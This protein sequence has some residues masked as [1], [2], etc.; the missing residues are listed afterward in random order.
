VTVVWPRA[1]P[2]Q[3]DWVTHQGHTV[4]QGQSPGRHMAQPVLG[5]TMWVS[6]PLQGHCAPTPAPALGTK[7]NPHFLPQS[8]ALR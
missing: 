3:S 8:Q 7:P 4:G 1:T 5:P 6:G 2:V